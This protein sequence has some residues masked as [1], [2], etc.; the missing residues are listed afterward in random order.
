MP[1]AVICKTANFFY[2][3]REDTPVSVDVDG[4][5]TIRNHGGGS[6]SNARVRLVGATLPPSRDRAGT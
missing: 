2:S 3:E 6:W 4:R 5:I 1:V